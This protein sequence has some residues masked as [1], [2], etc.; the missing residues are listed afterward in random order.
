VLAVSSKRSARM[1]AL[2]GPEND[3][4]GSE[5]DPRPRVGPA[6]PRKSDP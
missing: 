1:D 2:S 3:D 5:F 6:S 4:R